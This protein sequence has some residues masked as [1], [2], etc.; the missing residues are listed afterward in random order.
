MADD[1]ADIPHA[2]AFERLRAFALSLPETY[3]EFPWGECAVKVHGKT[4]LFT[5]NSAE[6]GLHLSFKLPRSCEFALEYPFTEPTGYGLGRAG[7]VTANFGSTD[8]PPLDVL[9][10]WIAESW[11]A[12]APKKLAARG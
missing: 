4:F 10:A 8:E 9:E 12:I 1:Q 6:N 7:W 5:R 2:A 3:E 11:R